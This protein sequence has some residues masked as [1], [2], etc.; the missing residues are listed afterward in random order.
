MVRAEDMMSRLGGDEF[1]CLAAESV[2]RELLGHLAGK[3]LDTVSA[4]LK[5][6]TLRISVR[7]SIG[8]ATY[9]ADRT[10]AEALLRSADE[11]MYRAK[12]QQIGYHFCD[13]RA[14]GQP[15]R[16]PALERP[17]PCFTRACVDGP[18]NSPRPR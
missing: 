17:R 18:A 12:Q 3:L 16:Q 14:D 7:P 10:T 1:A 9:P 6:G 8:I 4:P 2:N 15:G 5:P 13:R 11:A